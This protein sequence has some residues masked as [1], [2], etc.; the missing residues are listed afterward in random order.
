MDDFKRILVCLDLTEID[1]T[2]IKYTSRLAGLLNLEKVYFMHVSKSLELPGA[3]AK[4]Y[5]A[6]LAPTDES[7]A[8][9]VNGEVEKYFKNLE[10]VDFK[11]E[12]KEGNAEQ[13]ILKWSGIKE[14][15]LLIVGKKFNLKGKGLLPSR[16]IKVVHCSVLMI[17][18]NAEPDISKILVPV[19]FSKNSS[20]ALQYGMLMKEKT[21][22]KVFV[23]N[24]FHVPSGYHYTGKSYEE[25][26]E[27]MWE[28][29]LK[30]ARGYL[31][32]AN[33]QESEVEIV[34]SLDEDKEP[35]DKIHKDATEL[36]ADIVIIGSRGRTG[37]ASLFL[38]S[39]AEKVAHHSLKIPL[40]VVKTKKENMG[41]FEAL[42]KL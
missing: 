39:V 26:A 29:T 27:I 15:D 7:L 8:H 21:N 4:K 10:K 17:P 5:S 32:K 23:Q 38:G 2:L 12:I 24:T 28:N 30:D 11:I 20:P 19:D 3:I 34:L 35:S 33:I 1:E 16:L 6:M 40:L 31:K 37:I 42:M 36:G 18:E 41:F 9:Q 14:I 25:F 13:A 22:A